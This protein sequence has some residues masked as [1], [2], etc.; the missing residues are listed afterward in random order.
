[1]GRGP[2]VSDNPTS[3][4]RQPAPFPETNDG[5]GDAIGVRLVADHAFTRLNL[6]AALCRVL[7]LQ[8]SFP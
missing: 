2:A 6:R 7:A 5:S 1:M 4:L 3:R 8:R